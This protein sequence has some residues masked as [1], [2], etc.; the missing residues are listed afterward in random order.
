MDCQLDIAPN[1][2]ADSPPRVGVVI[3]SWNKKNDLLNL[4]GSL[5]TLNYPDADIIVID[6]ASDDGSAHEVRE[7][8][9]E[10]ILLVNDTNLGGT[11]G[12]NTGLDYC[13]EAGYDYIWLLDND[14]G[15]TPDAL[16]HLVV[17]AESDP[18]IGVVGSKILNAE[19]P[20]YIVKLGANIDWS[21]GCVRSISQNVR[22]F[23]SM[24]DF[25]DVDYVPFCSALIR[26]SCLLVAGRLDERFF[27]YWD[28]T[29]FCLRS[30]RHGYKTVIATK[31][32]VYHPSFT[33]K[34]R[35]YNYYLI[36][37]TFLFFVKHVKPIP[38]IRTL[39]NVLGRFIKNLFFAK[40]IGDMRGSAVLTK[41]LADFLR[42]RFGKENAV[43][44]L[45]KADISFPSL[46]PQGLAGS[47]IL[48]TYEGSADTMKLAF[49]QIP[50]NARHDATILVPFSRSD[51]YASHKEN[52]MILDD[53]VKNLFLE[54][55]RIF[56]KIVMERFDTVITTH[57]SMS[58]FAFA[59]SRTFFFDSATISFSKVPISKGKLPF[60]VA[61]IILCYLLT[62]FILPVFWVVGT[63]LVK[64]Q[65][66]E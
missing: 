35:E 18:M 56:L 65:Y 46:L 55:V 25:A 16:M 32:V 61:S 42:L 37:N 51:L 49:A 11:G 8:H 38:L 54:H 10:T 13:R 14:A 23:V 48:I 1:P 58:P 43:S 40:L 26:R 30:K 60:L 21:R 12:F 7:K 20:A 6:N 24:N 62:I 9:P 45:C 41:G 5:G 33:E 22:D 63:F 27:L 64:K 44:P 4:L 3:V 59:A 66:C 34:S 57:R 53:R 17:V 52:I 47:K 36:R 50:E 2:S 31:S 19:D 28:D 15:I 39:Y 29:D